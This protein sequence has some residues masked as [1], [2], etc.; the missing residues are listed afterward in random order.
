MWYFSAI[1]LYNTFAG[2]GVYDAT[3]STIEGEVGTFST[4]IADQVIMNTSSHCQSP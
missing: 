1:N 3:G 2:S 4:N